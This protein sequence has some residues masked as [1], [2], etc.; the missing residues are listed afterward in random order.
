MSELSSRAIAEANGADLAF[1]KFLSPNDTGLTG[2]HQCGI[3]VPKN[4]ISLIFDDGPFERGSN[5]DRWV[6]IEWNGNPETTTRSRFVYY[7]SGTR[8]EYRITNFGRGFALLKPE[9]T[10]DL[11]VICKIDE[12]LYRAFV[13]ESD[14]EIQ[15]FLDAFSIAPTELNSLIASKGRRQIDEESLFDQYYVRFGED[16]PTT[17]VMAVSAEEIDAIARGE[18]VAI[19][20][21][22]QIIRWIDVEYKLFRHIEERHYDYVT[23]EPAAS[24][25]EFIRT[26]LEITNR[27][28]SRAGKSLEH[29]LSA[30]FR[31]H[32]LSFSSQPVTEGNKKPDFIFPSEDAYH[33]PEFPEDKLTFLGA[34]TT[35]K[36]RWRQVLN[37][38]NRCKTKYLFTLQQGVSPNQLEEMHDENLILVVPKPYHR[39]YPAT[40]YPSIIS[41]EEFIQLVLQKDAKRSL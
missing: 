21:D 39:S 40:D 30:I 11:V 4:S 6:D 28:K 36:D 15:E 16:F 35:C 38:A 24:L 25:D 19:S 12:E 8:N 31:E 2:G 26:G 3:Y 41:L 1:A 18:D 23:L 7:G 33:D 17:Q 14:D 22:E 34:K 27:R 10:G 5:R 37:E 9:H 20:A 32:G 29:H 13:L